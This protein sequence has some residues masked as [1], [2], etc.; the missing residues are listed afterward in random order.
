[1]KSKD[2]S[3]Q[4]AQMVASSTNPSYCPDRTGLSFFKLAAGWGGRKEGESGEEQGVRCREHRE[5]E[6]REMAMNLEVRDGLGERAGRG[7]KGREEG[8]QNRGRAPRWG[9]RRCGEKTPGDLHLSLWS[10]S[11]T[12]DGELV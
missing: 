7:R 10:I 4:R 6:G 11:G 9:R 1:M 2:E 3:L 8:M 12:S 5:A